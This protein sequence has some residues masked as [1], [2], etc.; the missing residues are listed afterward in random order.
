MHNLDLIRYEFFRDEAAQYES[1]SAG[2]SDVFRDG[3]PN[4]WV[5]GYAFPRAESGEITFSEVPNSR[6]TGMRGFVFNTRRPIFQDIRVREALTLAFDFE[7][8]NQTLNAGAYKRIESYFSNSPLGFHGPARRR[9]AGYS[10]PRGRRA[11]PRRFG[12][13]AGAAD[14]GR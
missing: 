5:T 6:P 11:S 8:I 2:I 13:G 4:R 10:G 9:R 12:S 3:D 1:F 7:W 14:L